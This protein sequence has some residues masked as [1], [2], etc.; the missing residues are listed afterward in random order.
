MVDLSCEN[1]FYQFN[2]TLKVKSEMLDVRFYQ[3]NITLKVKSEM[4][5]T[6]RSP[7]QAKHINNSMFIQD[8][9]R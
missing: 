5:D 4:L 8:L 2:I 7:F 3:F 6:M 9:M 1:G